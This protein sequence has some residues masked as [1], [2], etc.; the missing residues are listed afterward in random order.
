MGEMLL[1]LFI[2]MNDSTGGRHSMLRLMLIANA[3]TLAC[4]VSAPLQASADK[5]AGWTILGRTFGHSLKYVANLSGSK[6]STYV[7]QKYEYQKHVYYQVCTKQNKQGIGL[8]PCM[9]RHAL[10]KYNQ[11]ILRQKGLVGMLNQ[12]YTETNIRKRTRH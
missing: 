6:G 10:K 8:G 4:L 1:L 12:Q 9:M 2:S 3:R 5:Y 7:N 11:T